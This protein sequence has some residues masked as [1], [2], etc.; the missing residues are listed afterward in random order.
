MGMTQ[1]D[2]HMAAEA[3][4]GG[5][6]WS[7]RA[8]CCFL[9]VRPAQDPRHTDAFQAAWEN[10]NDGAVVVG[11]GEQAVS[12]DMTTSPYLGTV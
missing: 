9:D 8:R 1:N 12:F 3:A 6:E 4:I 5:F 2:S 11:C 7:A 10:W